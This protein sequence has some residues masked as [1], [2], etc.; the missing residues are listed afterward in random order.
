MDTLYLL[1]SL[2]PEIKLIPVFP[3]FENEN[4]PNPQ[5]APIN[6][7]KSSEHFPKLNDS[8][9]LYLNSVGYLLENV[10]SH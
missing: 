4:P 6:C 2:F 3:H 1:A 10:S 7:L 8:L 5:T 9:D